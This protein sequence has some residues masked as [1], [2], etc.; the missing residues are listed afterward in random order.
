[1]KKWIV[2]DLE[3]TLT[4]N[5]HRSQL[6]NAKQWGEYTAAFK[7]DAIYEPVAEIFRRWQD[8]GGY[9]TICTGRSEATYSETW[10]WLVDRRLTPDGLLMR[11]ARSFEDDGEIKKL[12]MT[13]AWGSEDEVKANVCCVFDDSQ[14]VVDLLRQWG[15]PVFQVVL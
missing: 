5:R 7:D 9:V 6:A 13:A 14:F 10:Q 11:P 8:S 12:L 15:L 4:D 1:M 2:I 3:G